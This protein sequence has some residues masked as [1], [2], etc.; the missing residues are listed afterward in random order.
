[1]AKA[2]GRKAHE[3]THFI[4]DW[5]SV[6]YR[7]LPDALVKQYQKQGVS[8]SEL[9]DNQIAKAKQNGR[10]LSRQE[11]FDEVVADSMESMLADENAAAFLEKLAQRDK[12]LK[13]KVVGWLK[14]LAAKLKNAMTAYKDVKP[15]SPEGKIVAEMEDFR[16]EIMGIYTSALVDAGEN[17][18]ENGG[19][20]RTIFD[21]G[22]D[23]SFSIRNDIVDVNGVEYDNVVELEYKIFDRVKRRSKY[24]IDF[25][26]NNLIKEII[27]VLDHNGDSEIVEFASEKERVKKTGQ[28]THTLLS[29]S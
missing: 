26:R 24:Y 16:N 18:R 5:S 8:V 14:E 15:D 21:G 23:Y 19:D 20:K 7:T 28:I 27:T 22:E 6:K 11:A 25:I 10:E 4:K 13:E 29:E 1:M 3:L 2:T 12:G 9:V 17:F